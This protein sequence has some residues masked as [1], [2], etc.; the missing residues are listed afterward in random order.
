MATDEELQKR[1][2]KREKKHIYDRL[3]NVFG[4]YWEEFYNSI[5]V[6]E[7]EFMVSEQKE[8][9]ENWDT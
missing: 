5:S 7:E 1:R 9:K 2:H 6:F 4:P 8:A 3:I